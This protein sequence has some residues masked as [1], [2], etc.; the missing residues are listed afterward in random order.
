MSWSTLITYAM[1]LCFSDDT[2]VIP[3]SSTSNIKSVVG[4]KKSEDW[5]FV[6]G[7]HSASPASSPICTNDGSITQE[8]LTTSTSEISQNDIHAIQVCQDTRLRA[9][10]AE[11]N[12]YTA[13]TGMKTQLDSLCSRVDILSSRVAEQN[14]FGQELMNL[15]MQREVPGNHVFIFVHHNKIT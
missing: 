2:L 5:E 3:G 12:L 9:N 14:K 11:Y 1:C 10:A 4:E 6:E 8:T 13:V 15:L 7:D